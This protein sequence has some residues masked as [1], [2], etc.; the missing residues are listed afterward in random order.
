MPP[1]PVMPATRDYP[2]GRGRTRATARKTTGLPSRRHLLPGEGTSNAAQP[3]GLPDAMRYQLQANFVPRGEFHT[4]SNT[5][6]LEFDH[7]AAKTQEFHEGSNKTPSILL[8]LS[9]SSTPI[10][11]KIF[12]FFPTKEAAIGYLGLHSLPH[13]RHPVSITTKLISTTEILFDNTKSPVNS[14]NSPAKIEMEVISVVG[15][16]KSTVNTK[17]SV[18]G[19]ARGDL[20]CGFTRRI[21]QDYID[22]SQWYLDTIANELHGRLNEGKYL[23]V[24][25]DV[26]TKKCMGRFEEVIPMVLEAVIGCSHPF[27]KFEAAIMVTI[28]DKGQDIPRVVEQCDVQPMMSYIIK[29]DESLAP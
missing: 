13:L 24:F 8:K 5:F 15:N 28:P 16:P 29:T 20:C 9:A 23:I 10:Q 6:R 11:G 25:I 12:R 21:S 22:K 18:Y 7:W 17:F 14:Q 2:R 19:G 4:W 3:H 27:E 1:P 26:L